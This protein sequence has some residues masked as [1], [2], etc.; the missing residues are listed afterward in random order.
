MEP[1]AVIMNRSVAKHAL[2]LALVVLVICRWFEQ[3]VAAAPA[4]AARSAP[5]GSPSYAGVIVRDVPFVR[6]RPDFCGEACVEMYLRKLGHSIDQDQVF[7][8]SQLDP[9]LGRGCY[10]ADLERAVTNLGFRPGRVGSTVRVANLA[11]DMEA[12]WKKLHGALVGGVPSIVCMRFDA[13]PNTTEHF[14]LV[15]GYD[16]ARDEVIFHDPAVKEGAYQRMARATFLDLWPLKYATQE[17]T[18]IRLQLDVAQIKTPAAARGFQPADYCQHIFDLK[19]KLPSDNFKLLIEP[20]F[21]V[22]GDE[23]IETIKERAADTIAWAVKRLKAEYFARDPDHIIDVWLFKDTDSYETNVERLWGEK[24]TTPYGYYS[25]AN[26]ALVMNI[27]TGGG[28]LVHEIVHPFV[29]ANFR[30]CPDWLNEGLGSLYEQCGE[31]GGRIRGRTNWRL[32]G[33]QKAIRSDRVPSFEHLC[34]Q[35]GGKFYTADPG[36]N[37]SQARYLCYYLQERGLLKKFYHDF[38][39]N[40]RSDPTGY[41]TLKSTLGAQDMN[42]FQTDWEAYVLKLKF[43]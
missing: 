15:L 40:R 5:S 6:Q 3:F 9:A 35:T 39:A 8:A 42:V 25:P 28:T 4:N 22:V 2:F 36:T 37:Y 18:L 24:P 11:E 19:T 31:S 17:W 38:Y 23:P 10:T 43:P 32:A 13:R 29:R 30:E 41:E 12:N 21:V 1:G 20:P 33:L 14:R 7:A 16:P 34:S 27:S 26:R